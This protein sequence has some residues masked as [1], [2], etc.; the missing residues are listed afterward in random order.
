MSDMMST[1]PI[2]W[3]MFNWFAD[4]GVPR[5]TLFQMITLR[6][7]RGIKA[8]DGCLDADE[9][10]QLFVAFYE[11]AP[12]DCVCWCPR[13]NELATLFGRAFALGEDN[14]KDAS[15]YSFDSHLH[16]Y[17]DVLSWLRDGGRGVVVLDWSRAFD[18]LRDAPRIAVSERLLPTYRNAMQPSRM[19]ELSVISSMRLAA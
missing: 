18:R 9:T 16:L 15:T 8:A 11:D 3:R 13:T 2:D 4:Q 5:E 14:I 19:P 17:P 6:T 12:E 1:A 10:G 7:V